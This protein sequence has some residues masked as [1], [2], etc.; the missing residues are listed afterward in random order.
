MSGRYTADGRR[1]S[2]MAHAKHGFFCSCG[3]IVHGNGAKASHRAM[4]ERADDGHR[5]VIRESFSK[6]FPGV[7]ELPF[8]ER[9]ARKVDGPREP[10]T[11]SGER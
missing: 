2:S 1:R 4:H 5:Y 11:G 10:S 7:W 8:P 9:A 6:L 3:R